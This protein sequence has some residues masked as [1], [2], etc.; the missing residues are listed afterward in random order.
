MQTMTEMNFGIGTRCAGPIP[1]L[2]VDWQMLLIRLVGLIAAAFVQR[3]YLEVLAISQL[4]QTTGQFSPCLLTD[5]IFCN[6]NTNRDVCRA[7][8][9]TRFALGFV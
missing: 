7:N 6:G 8:T 1:T 5:L 2:S 3:H 9:R 4:L